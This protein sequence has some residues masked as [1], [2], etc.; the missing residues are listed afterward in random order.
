[1]NLKNTQK[2]SCRGDEIKMSEFNAGD[3]VY[4]EIFKE[5]LNETNPKRT[6]DM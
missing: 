2:N 5:R 6:R 1:M 3:K 4:I